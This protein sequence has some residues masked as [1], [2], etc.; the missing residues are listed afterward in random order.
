MSRILVTGAC[1]Q[2]GSELVPYLA[3]KHGKDSILASD[4]SESCEN[5]H[6]VDYVELDVT[7]RERIEKVVRDYDVDTIYHLAAILSAT[8]E[9]KPFIAFD[10]NLVGTNNILRVGAVKNLSRIIIPSTIGVFGPDTP[11][12][13]VPVVTVTR[14]KTMYG[15]TKIAT[16]ML[17]DY[18]FEKFGLDVRGLRFPGIMSY[19]REPTAGTTDYS[20]QMFYHAVRGEEYTCFLKEDAYLPMMYMPDAVSSLVKLAEA[21][22]ASLT[23]HTDYNIMSYSFSPAELY[24]AIRSEIPDFHVKYEPDYRQ[25]IAETWPGSLDCSLAEKDW[26]F[27]PEYD[28]KRTVRDM[29]ENLRKKIDV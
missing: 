11:K 4:V 1:G 14:P 20:V 13:D 15:I 22:L 23:R 19:I 6:D 17:G 5:Y 28:L 25:D 21:D 24:E 3:R 18:Y 26:G 27:R 29:I 12:N 16:E 2:I 7:D 9:R 8:G 10:V